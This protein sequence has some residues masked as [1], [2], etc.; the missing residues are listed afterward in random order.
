ME[1]YYWHLH[2]EHVQRI[3]RSS[4]HFE[5]VLEY[6]DGAA[7]SLVATATKQGHAHVE[8]NGGNERGPRKTAHTPLTAL[9]TAC[10]Q[11]NIRLAWE[12]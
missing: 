12:T 2:K 5:V 9:F 3:S 6:S 8:Q 7:Q 1:S 10:T 4:D 11:A